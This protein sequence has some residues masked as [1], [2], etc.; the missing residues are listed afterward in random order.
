M[1]AQGITISPNVQNLIDAPVK[2][3]WVPGP[4]GERYVGK[5]VQRRELVFSVQVHDDDPDMWA[6]I[7]ARWR[8]A[9]DYDEEATMVVTTSDGRRSINLR[10]LEQ[11]K[12]YDQKD[13]HITADNPVVMTVAAE[14]PYWTEEPEVVQWESSKASDQT[15]FQVANKGDV[16][17]WLRWTLTAPGV[18]TLPD[19]SWGNDM[20]SRA[21]DD[22]ERTVDVPALVSGEH[23]VVDSDPRKQ[24]IIAANGNPVQHRWSGK[25]LLYPLMPGK[26]GAVP[27]AFKSGVL[28]LGLGIGGAGGSAQLTVPKWFSRPWSRP[29]VIR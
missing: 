15:T 3:L 12:P 20:F 9:W 19:F 5:R 17:V 1:G 23:V 27:L 22:A 16:P 24:T 14:F 18:W 10:L 6:E 11:P 29:S 2:T 8:W 7:D 4:F 26:Q 21:I 25:D 13:P 28:G